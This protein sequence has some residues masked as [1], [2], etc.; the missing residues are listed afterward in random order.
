MT[1]MSSTPMTTPALL[2]ELSDFGRPRL[3]AD[4]PVLWRAADVIQ[5]GDDITMTSITRSHVAWM[6][7]LD[8]TRTP[9]ELERMLTIPPDQARRVIRGLLAAGALDDA[10]RVAES[11]RWAGPSERADAHRRFSSALATYRDLE[12]AH[13]V[14]RRRERT[15]IGVIGDGR[16]AGEIV[17]ALHAGGLTADDDRAD[18]FVLADAVHPSVPAH[19]DDPRMS[20]PHLHVGVYAEWA[21]VGPLV[22]PGSTS[23][24]RCQHLHR[25]DADPSWPLVSVQWSHWLS[26]VSIRP[27]D[28]LLARL[29]ADWA[30]LLVRAWIDLPDDPAAWADT[31]VDLRLPLPD[32]QQRRCPPH[33]LCGCRWTVD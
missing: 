7:T 27:V 16:I 17:E 26:G 11:V 30:A 10:D 2:A 25:R 8:G 5:I 31:A 1:T 18:L 23:C 33:P 13:A 6:S 12:T 28:P 4:I 9:A 21:T 29:A 3:R 24:L 20:H 15:R 22:V 14:T 19:F 32:P